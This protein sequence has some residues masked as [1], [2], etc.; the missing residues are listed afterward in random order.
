MEVHGAGDTPVDNVTSSSPRRVSMSQHSTIN[1][2]VGCPCRGAAEMPPEMPPIFSSVVFSR[3]QEICNYYLYQGNQFIARLYVNQ[4]LSRHKRLSLNTFKIRNERS[5]CLHHIKRRSYYYGRAT[6]ALK[7]SLAPMNG[8]FP[9]IS[10]RSAAH[11]DG[12]NV[13]IPSLSARK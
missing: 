12:R 7:L 1:I 11:T 3:F 9:N 13:T 8:A 5:L 6:G 2:T 10:I 4:E